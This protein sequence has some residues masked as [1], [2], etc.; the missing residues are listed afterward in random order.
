MRVQV[1]KVRSHQKEPDGDEHSHQLWRGNHKADQIASQ[2][3]PALIRADPVDTWVIT[4][5]ALLND[6]LPLCDRTPTGIPHG[7]RVQGDG[8]R[9]AFLSQH[10]GLGQGTK[11]V[12]RH[13]WAPTGRCRWQCGLCGRLSRRP[14][15]PVGGKDCAGTLALARTVHRSHRLAVAQAQGDCATVLVCLRCGHYASARVASLKG[16]CLQADAKSS[17]AL[18]AFKAP[19]TGAPLSH[20]RR[21]HWYDGCGWGVRSNPSMADSAPPGTAFG[22]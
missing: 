4:T 8:R 17:R 2:V 1:A 5:R 6:L 20:V 18:A 16:P 22:Q 19:T 11:G 7:L 21:C 13:A 3:L 15:I 12:A 10:A 14:G 9:R